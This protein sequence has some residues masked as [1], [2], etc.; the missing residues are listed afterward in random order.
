MA[1]HLCTMSRLYPSNMS[2]C[3][4]HQHV[5][6]WP[7]T[8]FHG[9]ALLCGVTLTDKE[10]SIQPD[11]EQ[12]DKMNSYS[13][14]CTDGKTSVYRGVTVLSQDH[15]K[16]SKCLVLINPQALKFDSVVHSLYLSTLLVKLHDIKIHCW[17]TLKPWSFTANTVQTK[18]KSTIKLNFQKFLFPQR[19][20]PNPPPPKKKSLKKIKNGLLPQKIADTVWCTFLLKSSPPAGW[21]KYSKVSAKCKCIKGDVF[22]PNCISFGNTSNSQASTPDTH[23]HLCYQWLQ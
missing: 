13:D 6:T 4:P 17:S 12:C 1:N 2:D 23:A 18:G 15:T 7:V 21:D 14:C 20:N 8:I 11:L 19:N 10:G 3:L 22:C 9:H 5:C 16:P